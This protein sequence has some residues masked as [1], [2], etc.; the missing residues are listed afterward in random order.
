MTTEDLRIGNLVQRHE[1]TPIEV[2]SV[3]TELS[4]ETD[5]TNLLGIEHFKPIPLTEEWLFK[6]GF[7]KALNGW[8]DKTETWCWKD[9]IFYLGA[10]SWLAECK[11]VHQLQNLYFALTGEELKT[12]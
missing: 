2:V 9:D 3:I 4:I 1:L 8:W 12:K 5:F 11:Y 10:L 7:E 6:F